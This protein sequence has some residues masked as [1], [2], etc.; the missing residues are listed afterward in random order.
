MFLNDTVIT[1]GD[2][3]GGVNPNTMEFMCNRDVAM[4]PRLAGLSFLLT[5][6][7]ISVVI[8]VMW[9]LSRS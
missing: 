5:L 7:W 9:F 6:S 8:F 2:L 4:D 3:A 1:F